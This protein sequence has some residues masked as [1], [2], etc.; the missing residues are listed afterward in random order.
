MRC[1]EDRG[2]AAVEFALVAVFLIP[3]IFGIL[4]YGLWF[5]DSLAT[6]DGARG[7][8]RSGALGTYGSSC[9]TDYLPHPGTGDPVAQNLRNLACTAVEQTSALAGVAYVRI[10]LVPDTGSGLTETSWDGAGVDEPRA[11]RVCVAV[12]HASSIPG[13]PLPNGGLV[14]AKVQMPLETPPTPEAAGGG[15]DSTAPTDWS[16]C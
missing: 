16:W 6:R 15:Y 12:Q 14:T 10:R 7:A 9:G 4:D 5:A 3:L 13:I 1:R 2:A 8:A 11:I